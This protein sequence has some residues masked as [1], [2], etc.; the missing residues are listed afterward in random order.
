MQS[1]PPIWYDGNSGIR[2]KLPARR[3]GNMAYIRFSIYLNKTQMT[4]LR[5]I[6]IMICFVV[7]KGELAFKSVIKACSVWGVGDICFLMVTWLTRS[8]CYVRQW[9]G[10]TGVTVGQGSI[11]PDRFPSLG[12]WFSGC[13]LCIWVEYVVL[14]FN[15]FPHKGHVN[16]NKAN[17]QNCNQE[18]CNQRYYAIKDDM[19]SRKLQSTELCIRVTLGEFYSWLHLVLSLLNMCFL[20]FLGTLKLV[21]QVMRS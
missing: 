5:L 17:Q 3:D 15:C 19:Q 1:L 2:L 20:F 11:K 16:L 9:L 14:F 13:I 8:P 12:S 21:S 7:G 10:R 4:F 6:W 18:Q